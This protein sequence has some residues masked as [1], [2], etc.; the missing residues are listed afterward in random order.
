MKF[1]LLFILCFCTTVALTAQTNDEYAAIDA[2]M[3]QIPDSS[4]K[5][6][7]SIARYI[8]SK[9]T[10][11]HDKIRAIYHWITKNIQYDI[12]NMYATNLH[13]DTKGLAD[14]L[15][16][17][18]KG[19]CI[20]YAMLFNNIAQQA[21]IKSYVIQG[22]TK[23]NGAVDNIPHAW[24]AACIDTTWYLFDPTWG[25]GG[26]TNSKYVSRQNNF[27]FKTKPESLIKSHM[28]FDPQ[29]QL[30]NYP[31]GYEEFCNLKAGTTYKKSYFNFN[32]SIQAYEKRSEEEQLIITTGRMEKNKVTNAIVFDRLQYNKREIEYFENTRNVDYYNAAINY[33]NEGINSLNAFINYRN[34]H[35]TPTKPDAELKVM[36]DTIDNCF[37]LAKSKMKL[38][39]GKD[40][41][42]QKSL[43]QLYKS[44]E[45]A[46]LNLE[47][48]KT[49][50]KKYLA[51]GKLFRKASF[52]KF[53]WL[54]VP[55]K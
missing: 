45:E 34:N 35:F 8:N 46:S 33:Y 55:A 24:C 54:G 26:V 9:F 5:S 44:I 13:E 29:W 16:K 41:N 2:K 15:L 40:A 11:K 50:L 21:G 39:G 17:S 1:K 31:V 52:Y 42:T 4:T 32:D 10:D 37:T 53:T 27:F 18:R 51:T 25:A 12:K 36:L 47:E 28:P 30:L 6:T 22:F 7:Q 14:K 3:L 38:V 23:Q 19:V 20:D 48:Q 49:F 43:N